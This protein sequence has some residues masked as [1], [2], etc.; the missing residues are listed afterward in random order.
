MVTGD[1]D[2]E[3]V[4]PRKFSWRVPRV[5]THPQA[6]TR[7]AIGRALRVPPGSEAVSS[8][9]LRVCG[10]QGDPVVGVQGGA[11]PWTSVRSEEAGGDGRKSGAPIVAVKP[12]NAGGAKGCRFEITEKG[13]TAL[14]REGLRP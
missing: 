6:T 4:E 2:R 3:G 13:H 5:L 7:G 12:G 8:L 9:T 11:H 14:H 10:N 1:A